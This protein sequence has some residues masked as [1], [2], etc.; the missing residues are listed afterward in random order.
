MSRSQRQ[1][2]RTSNHR[3]G[4]PARA[5]KWHIFGSPISMCSAQTYPEW[6]TDPGTMPLGDSEPAGQDCKACWY[7]V[8]R[9]RQRNKEKE[10]ITV[11]DN[12]SCPS[13]GS[14][15]ILHDI[16]QAKAKCRDCTYVFSTEEYADAFVDELPEPEVVEV[17]VEEMMPEDDES[18][19]D[20]AD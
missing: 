5:R 12:P 2:K 9:M 3:F 6:K 14:S 1:T 8:M 4:K 7:A 18:E 20:D 19:A 17:V 11:Q 13:C 10:V 15:L 16:P